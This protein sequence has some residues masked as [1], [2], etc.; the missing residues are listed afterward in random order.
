MTD[1]MF[2]TFQNQLDHM[3][4]DPVFFVRKVFHADP[5][6]Q[7]LQLLQAIAPSDARVSAS[8]GVGVG[9]TAALAWAVWW[10]VCL[11]PN[12]KT[13]ATAPT[14]SQMKDALVPEVALWRERMHP[15][16]KQQVE[17]TGER[18][19]VKGA[20]STQFAAFKTASKHRPEAL[21]GLHGDH[22]LA[23]IDEASGVDD[24]VFKPLRGATGRCST[25]VVMT[26]NPTRTD[27][28][29][30]QSHHKLR[31]L[32]TTFKFSAI[33]SP[34]AP[35]FLEEELRAEYGVADD[36]YRVRILGEF[37]SASINQLIPRELAEAASARKLNLMQYNHAPKVLG[38]DVAWEGDD[39]SCVYLRQG[40]HAQQL[41]VWRSIDNMTLGGL[42]NQMWSQ[43]DVDACFID[44]GWGTGVIDYLR[45]IGRDPIPVN[46]GGKSISPEYVNKRTEMWCGLKKWLEDG[47]LIPQSNDLIED[48]VGPEYSFVPNGAKALESKKVMKARG[49]ASPDLADALALTF[50]S[51]VFKRQPHEINRLK[52][53]D[54]RAV[55]S[56]QGAYNP[57]AF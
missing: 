8:S 55:F 56:N 36:M 45:S 18:A 5:T 50:A 31:D 3:R 39:R 27:G 32:W 2:D 41:G 47:G 30:Y 14:K 43:H 52:D 35:K 22:V 44:V 33:D 26:A 42:I 48:L 17:V 46:F 29:F 19:F 28:Y 51:P 25:R 40:L 49:L 16:F 34:I 10:H 53:Y 38:V 21:Q 13:L 9:K 7:Q 1:P 20:E 37:P 57:L 15:W 12:S 4:E 23:I 24:V 6:T 54:K 11:F